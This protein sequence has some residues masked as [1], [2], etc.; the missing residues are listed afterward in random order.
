MGSGKILRMHKFYKTKIQLIRIKKTIMSNV[1]S[2]LTKIYLLTK[3][4]LLISYSIS[5]KPYTTNTI[6]Y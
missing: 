2:S 5:S 3:I 4:C 1:M 6:Y